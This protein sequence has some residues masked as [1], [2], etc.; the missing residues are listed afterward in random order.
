[1]EKT[2]QENVGYSDQVVVLLCFVER[3]A[4]VAVCPFVLGKKERE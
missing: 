2:L 3:V 1:M 4:A